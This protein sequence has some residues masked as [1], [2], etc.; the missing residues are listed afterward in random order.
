LEVN[1]KILHTC[2]Y[3]SHAAFSGFSYTV[4][5][6]CFLN[7]LIMIMLIFNV[8]KFGL[9]FEHLKMYI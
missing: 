2:F 8:E 4:L 7:K 6:F 1:K 5:V 9:N 3:C